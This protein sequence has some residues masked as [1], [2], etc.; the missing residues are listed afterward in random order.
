MIKKVIERMRWEEYRPFTL[1]AGT[2]GDI[3]IFTPTLM[4]HRTY[5]GERRQ[6]KDRRTG[7]QNSYFTQK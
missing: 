5:T 4:L 2:E 1:V 7:Q 6:T 3:A